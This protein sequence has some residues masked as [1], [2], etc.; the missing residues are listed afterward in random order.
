MNL[1]QIVVL[2]SGIS[3]VPVL[4]NH[5]DIEIKN[6]KELIDSVEHIKK[7]AAGLVRFSYCQI[8]DFLES[9]K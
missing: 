8:K 9:N 2:V 1:K 3:L 6:K 4:I 5:F 7:G